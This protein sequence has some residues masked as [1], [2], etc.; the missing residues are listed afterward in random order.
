[1]TSWKS[2]AA[3][4]YYL[5]I[6]VAAEKFSWAPAAFFVFSVRTVVEPVAVF[7]DVQVF[8]ARA[9]ALVRVV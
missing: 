9:F 7:S 8:F 6:E 1:M 4:L 3:V 5:L 2:I